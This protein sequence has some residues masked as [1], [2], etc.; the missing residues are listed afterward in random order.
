MIVCLKFGSDEGITSVSR[1]DPTE[2]ELLIPCQLTNPST[3][4]GVA[5]KADIKRAFASLPGVTH[6]PH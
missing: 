1:H 2:L 4:V 5:G 3:R 6:S